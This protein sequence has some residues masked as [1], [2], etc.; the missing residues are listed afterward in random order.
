MFKS[1]EDRERLIEI[2]AKVVSAYVANNAVAAESVPNLIS[3]I[4]SRLA[5]LGA[6]VQVDDAPQPIVPIKKTITSDFLISLEDGKKYKALRRHLATRGL[7][8]DEY[9][10]KWG[11]PKDYPMVAPSYSARRSELAR[12]VGLGKISKVPTGRSARRRKTA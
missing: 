10:E 1:V 5:T 12:E 8:P 6:P 4:S 7:T 9:R 2:T 11:L 3:D